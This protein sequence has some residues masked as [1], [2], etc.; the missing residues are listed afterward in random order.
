M[1]H[2][3]MS[4]FALCLA[5]L[6][7]AAQS[8][9]ALQLGETREQLVAR[10]GAPGAEDHG[11]NLA[12]YFWEGWSAQLEF[13]DN[14]VRKLT[15]RRNWYLQEAEITSLLDSNGGAS[16]WHETSGPNDLAR[17][18]ARD[19]G[20]SATCARVRPVSIVFQAAGL[21]A[22][23]QQGPKVV[24]PATPGPAYTKAPTFPKM[25]GAPVEPELPIADPP[26]P[27]SAVSS[28]PP[29]PKL[30]TAELEPET[31]PAAPVAPEPPPQPASE[32]K[33]AA[34]PPAPAATKD[35][36]VLGYLL[37]SLVLLGALAAGGFFLLRRRSRPGETPKAKFQ[38]IDSPSTAP[39]SIP[40]L[41]SL[42]TDQ[43]E[44][45]IGEI[46]R[47]EGYTI[48]LSA[49]LNHEDGIDLM[50]RRESETTLVQCKYWKTARVSSR[51][52][53]EFYGTM[54]AGGAP[55][56]ILVTTGSF[57]PDATEF[58]DGKG[59][60]LIDGATLAAKITAVAKPGENL[61]TVS[62]WIDDFVAHARIF[63][64]EC[65]VCHGTM[66]IRNN[67]ASGAP[68]WSCRGYPRCPGRREPRLDLLPSSAPH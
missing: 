39:N 55:H 62:T 22:A 60:Q 48:E 2:A 61:C 17:Q 51:E 13:K 20:A 44:L 15:Y 31:K 10:H 16:H 45:L 18:W 1:S 21:A 63:D 35:P 67:R 36:H 53:R 19:D 52:M 57:T 32:Q 43:V 12:A 30:P 50:L 27:A 49:G 40:A 24:V 5:L 14:V 8:A 56:G 4:R 42:R 3:R 9:R 64:P 34:E 23:Y 47:R 41:E 29:L 25:L 66:V 28:P 58:A 37:G 26:P 7:V 46:F 59:I 65:P 54:A 68:S 33:A 38:A 6:C 11:R